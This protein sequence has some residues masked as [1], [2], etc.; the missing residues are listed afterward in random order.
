MIDNLFI[1]NPVC[2]AISSFVN[3]CNE[4]SYFPQK[5]LKFSQKMPLSKSVNTNYQTR[6][7]FDSTK[8]SGVDYK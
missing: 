1:N 6:F 4:Q 5:K 7:I 3:F 8:I 2:R